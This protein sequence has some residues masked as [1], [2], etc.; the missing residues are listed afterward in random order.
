MRDN[1]ILSG[2]HHNARSTQQSC[3]R[4]L[5]KAAQ[6]SML[7]ALVISNFQMTMMPNDCSSQCDQ[8]SPSCSRCLRLRIGCVGAGIQ[9]FVF[10]ACN[11]ATG[12]P[13]KHHGKRTTPTESSSR[14]G[15]TKLGSTI[16][17]APSSP[18]CTISKLLV[19]NL[20]TQ[21]LRY[22]IN[23]AHG[24][25]LDELPKRLE[26]SEALTEATAAFMLAVPRS[27][28][29]FDLARQRLRSYTAAMKATRLALL[30]PAEAYSLN[31]MCAVYFL[32]VVQVCVSCSACEVSHTNIRSDRSRRAG[33]TF[34]MEWVS[35]PG[36]WPNCST[37]L[38]A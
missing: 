32:W 17:R 21:N 7:V 35:I 23:W 2:L 10:K 5:S 19:S 3:L 29:P 28:I 14:E 34:P 18:R 1:T 16:P 31:T 4:S 13:D 15:S 12:E 30:N 36:G 27:R 33:S 6:E 20:R 37:M 9:R 11:N 8:K 25:F 26:H 22:D 38:L 24:P